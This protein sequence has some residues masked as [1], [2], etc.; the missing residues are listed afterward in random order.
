MGETIKGG[1]YIG[2]DG[3]AHDAQGR[4]VSKRAAKQAGDDIAEAQEN[5]PEALRQ[6]IAELEARLG[7]DETTNTDPNKGG[8]AGPGATPTE[9]AA[10]ADDLGRAASRRGMTEAD[11]NKPRGATPGADAGAPAGGSVAGKKVAEQPVPKSTSRRG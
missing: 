9:D 10:A 6:R 7:A 1:L 3:Q 11:V 5:D 8:D 4:P 2:A